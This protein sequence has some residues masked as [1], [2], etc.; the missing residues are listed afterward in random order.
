MKSTFRIALIVA[1]YLVAVNSLHAAAP[2]TKPNIIM[3]LFDDL[4][5]GETNLLS[6]GFTIQNPQH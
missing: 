6:R 1:A 3:V 5:Y 2:T 4:G